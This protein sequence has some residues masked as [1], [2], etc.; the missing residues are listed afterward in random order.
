MLFGQ[1][2]FDRVQNVTLH[3]R[4]RS[5]SLPLNPGLLFFRKVSVI[6]IAIVLMRAGGVVSALHG[7]SMGRGKDLLI[8]VV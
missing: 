1:F 5:G 4:T 6:V 8:S 2:F 7:A 3:V